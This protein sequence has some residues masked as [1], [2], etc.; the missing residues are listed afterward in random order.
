MRR[1]AQNVVID[2]A[3]LSDPGRDPSKQINEDS[4]AYAE[5]PLGHL[6]VLCDGMGGHVGGQEAS[7][8]AAMQVTSSVCQAPATSDA[9]TALRAALES[10]ARAVFA[11]GAE[12]PAD[13]RPGSTCVAVLIHPAGVSVA[14]VG[15]SR[16]YLVRDS[17]ITRLTRD[18]SVVQELLDAGVLSRE[19]AAQHPDANQITRALGTRED[20]DVELSGTVALRPRD[21]LLLCSDGLSDLVSDAE[22]CHAVQT[23]IL[24]GPAV[25]C[26]QLVDL[27]NQR[28]GHDNISIQLIEIIDIPQAQAGPLP[29][30]HELTPATVRTVVGDQPTLV[31][32]GPSAG[33]GETQLLQPVHGESREQLPPPLHHEPVSATQLDPAP[34][35]ERSHEARFDPGDH[36]VAGRATG[37]GR[38]AV[39]IAAILAGLIL[40]SIVGWW[41]LGGRSRAAPPEPTHSVPLLQPSQA[42][43]PVLELTP[44]P[45]TD[46]ETTPAPIPPDAQPRPAEA[47]PRREAG[48][49]D[50]GVSP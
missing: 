29:T 33:R 15:D 41:L 49:L 36:D 40:A 48:A 50:A 13:S 4:T 17:N 30:R 11:L 42:S 46:P 19:A 22:L 12:L 3:E 21:S 8:L 2:F 24:S 10:A 23:S 25:A 43:A 6:A 5:T 1:T 31:N 39:A 20:V 9:K 44:Q 27:A 7:K 35:T 37:T 28:G 32:D 14:H 26:Q 38:H 47:G 34:Y 16:C 18:H 45:S